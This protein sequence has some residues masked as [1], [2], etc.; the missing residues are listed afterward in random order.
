MLEMVA[1]IRCIPLYFSLSYPKNINIKIH[2]SINL[3]VFMFWRNFIKRA[4]GHSAEGK[5]LNV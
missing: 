4:L 5:I 1:T 2:K 3:L